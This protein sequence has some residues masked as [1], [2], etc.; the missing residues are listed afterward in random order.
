MEMIL[1]VFFVEKICRKKLV[2]RE[3]EEGRKIR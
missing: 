3:E 2:V 1:G